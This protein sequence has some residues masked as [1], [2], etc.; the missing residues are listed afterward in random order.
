MA[1]ALP[2]SADLRL[3]SRDSP[4]AAAH[5]TE[6]QAE[7]RRL[8]VLQPD[9]P[10]SSG[11]FDDNTEMAVRR[12]QWFAGQVPGALSAE[13]RFDALEAVV[14]AR[15]SGAAE[16]ELSGGERHV[17]DEHEKVGRRVP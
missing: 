3:G 6:L 14:P 9:E 17:I 4:G 2:V 13:G 5:V 12:F 11:E 8:Q 16:L 1:F 10:V 7:L 15:R